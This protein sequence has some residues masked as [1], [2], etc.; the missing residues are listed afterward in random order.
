MNWIEHVSLWVVAPTM[1]AGLLVAHE[2]GFRLGSRAWGTE[3]G[4]ERGYLVSSA[5]ALLGLLMAFTFNAAHDRFRL[6]QELV[7]SEANAISTTYLRFQLLDQPWRG[8]LS[9]QMLQYA[10]VRVGFA[11]ASTPDA[12]AANAVQTAAVQNKI[13]PELAGAL[14]AN[15][16]PALNLAL[17][18]SVNETFDLA[19]TRRAARETRVPPV[20]L[21]A[22]I[23]SSMMVAAIVGYAG[24]AR[25]RHGGIAAGVM[26]LLTLA[27]CLILDLDRPVVGSVQINQAPMEYAL[28][29]IRQ[30]EARAPKQS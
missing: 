12:I 30:S 11:R 28:D 7:V 23:L 17:V 4:E 24:A 25:R 8:E 26:A 20:I 22:L 16:S 15:S 1:L 18:N 19:A 9:R 13:W 2:I 6:R 21:Y 5:L 3:G 14:R 27:F 10:G 29:M